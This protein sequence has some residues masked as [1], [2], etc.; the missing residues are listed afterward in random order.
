MEAACTLRGA[1]VVSLDTSPQMRV[2]AAASSRVPVR[3]VV[4]EGGA[5]SLPPAHGEARLRGNAV[6]RIPSPPVEARLW[7]RAA[8]ACIPVVQL[9]ISNLPATFSAM[10]KKGKKAAPVEAPKKKK[11]KAAGKK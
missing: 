6:V 4:A 2:A 8:H 7:L 3:P 10:A 11:K 5:T 1:A 9:S